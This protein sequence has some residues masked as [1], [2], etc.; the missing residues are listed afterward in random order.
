VVD[1]AGPP[2]ASKTILLV[3]DEELVR[4]GT[5]DM[6]TDMGHVVRQ[7]ASGAQALQMLRDE[8]FD[9]LVSDYLMPGMTGVELLEEV[10]RQGRDLPALLITGFAAISAETA[11]EHRRL[12]KPFRRADLAVALAG[13]FPADAA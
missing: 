6:L 5:A 1:D 3:D 12:A 7:A 8:R 11:A 2:L 9:A 4:T 13:L 10:R